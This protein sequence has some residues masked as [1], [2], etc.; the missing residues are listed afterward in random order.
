MDG[1]GDLWLMMPARKYKPE[2]LFPPQ[3]SYHF[4][5]AG[6]FDIYTGLYES[7]PAWSGSWHRSNQRI[8]QEWLLQL[9]LV[10]WCTPVH[11]VIVVSKRPKLLSCQDDGFDS[12]SKASTW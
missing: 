5:N 12:E 7:S 10:F 8:P 11:T 9:G 2:C 6:Y 4:I 3:P 1:Y